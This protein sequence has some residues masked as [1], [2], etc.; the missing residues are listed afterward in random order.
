MCTLQWNQAWNK[1]GMFWNCLKAPK[2]GQRAVLAE[3]T[4][5]SAK[6]ESSDE[7][8][9][10]GSNKVRFYVQKLDNKYLNVERVVWTT[11][12]VHFLS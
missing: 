4:K 8:A 7:R 6:S 3:D 9:D 5:V 12:M 1:W 11:Q 10:L 2:F